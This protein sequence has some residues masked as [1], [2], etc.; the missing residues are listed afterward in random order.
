DGEMVGKGREEN[1]G[2]GESF[3]KRRTFEMNDRRAVIV[4]VCKA[5]APF[6]TL[7]VVYTRYSQA[8]LYGPRERNLMSFVLVN[9]GEGTGGHAV[10]GRTEARTGLIALTSDQFFWKTILYFLGSTG[11]PV[12]FGVTIALGFIFFFQAEDGIRYWSV[13]G[14][15]TCA[16]PI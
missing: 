15:Q 12:N 3:K 4:G 5:S 13:T 8:S 11:I 7:P 10:G 6:T 2:G 16:L 1:M 14:V 9:P